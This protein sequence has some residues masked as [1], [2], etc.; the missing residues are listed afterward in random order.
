MFT[1]PFTIHILDNDHVRVTTPI[2]SSL[3]GMYTHLVS[4]GFDCFNEGD[5]VLIRA[6]W[7]RVM[8]S[9]VRYGE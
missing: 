9:L 4:D 6:F 7:R 1:P 2:P 5:A 3:D 8:A